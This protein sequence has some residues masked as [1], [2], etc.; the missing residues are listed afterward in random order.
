MER[1]ESIRNYTLLQEYEI[2]LTGEA[3]YC[4]TKTTAS[5]MVIA[6]IWLYLIRKESRKAGIVL[7]G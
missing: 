3:A 1:A 2:I 4:V 7:P 5:V 6:T